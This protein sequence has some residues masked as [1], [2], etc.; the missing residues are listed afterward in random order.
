MVKKVQLKFFLFFL[1]KIAIYLSLDPIKDVNASE[2]AFSPKKS[3]S[4][5][6]K[7]EIY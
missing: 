7:N 4:G 5:P 6:S 1:P 3:T 2:E